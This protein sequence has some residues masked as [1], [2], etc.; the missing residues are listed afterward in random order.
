LERFAP[1]GLAEQQDANG[2]NDAIQRLQ[3]GTLMAERMAL[4]D[5]AMTVRSATKSVT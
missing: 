5:F 3:H 2:T 4:T 1:A